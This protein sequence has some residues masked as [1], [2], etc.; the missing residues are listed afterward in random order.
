MRTS[1]TVRQPETSRHCFSH[2][3]RP[4]DRV[5]PALRQARLTRALLGRS[6]LH[7]K[8]LETKLGV[9]MHLRSWAALIL[10]QVGAVE[11]VNATDWR[12]YSPILT[13]QTLKL[14]SEEA[15]KLLADFCKT[16]V[17]FVKGVGDTC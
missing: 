8:A 12:Y 16:P 1:F 17:H 15:N 10:V 9:N 13:S 4:G 5:A 2:C 6:R 7:R 3:S 11:H 14:G